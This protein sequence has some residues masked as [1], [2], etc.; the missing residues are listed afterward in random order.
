MNN[1]IKKY[2]NGYSGVQC[3]NCIKNKGIADNDEFICS[4]GE[5][6][7]IGHRFDKCKFFK[8]HYKY[9]TCKG[10][11]KIRNG[12]VVGKD[13]YSTFYKQGKFKKIELCKLFNGGL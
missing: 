6:H 12:Y 13:K 10:V 9:I 3:T 4:R 5:K 8:R 7:Y 1:I 2:E 11:A